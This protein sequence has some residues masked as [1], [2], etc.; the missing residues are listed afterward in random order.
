MIRFPQWKEQEWEMG[1]FYK[2]YF[3]HPLE[4][5]YSVE[6]KN[7]L[8]DLMNKSQ[9]TNMKSLRCEKYARKSKENLTIKD[10]VDILANNSKLLINLKGLFLGEYCEHI[11]I[12]YKK[13]KL[14]I[15]SIYPIFKAYPSLEV[16][17][18]C[19]RMVEEDIFKSNSQLLEIRSSNGNSIIPNKHLTHHNL[20][21]LIVEAA[22]ISEKNLAKICN[23]DLP[24]LE[25]FE[26]C[27]GR[28]YQYNINIEALA[29]ILSG[30]SF[31]NLI[32]LAIRGT[33]NTNEIA[34]GIAKS[35]ILKKLRVLELTDGNLANI[36]ANAL[37]QFPAI[38]HLHTL[39]I[40]GN[41]LNAQMLE[42]LSQLKCR[43]RS[44]INYR[45]YSV[46]E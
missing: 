28:D 7:Q 35:P 40:S 45:Y 22:E 29:P 16:L 14:D 30:K 27:L 23:L 32:F 33:K 39:D 37:I 43:V 36:G 17:H 19:G 25:Y 18:L 34:D 11:N 24:S 15:S 13:S 1:G 42:K 5:L 31:P 4:R 12:K 3:G 38:N 44:H 8:L 26:L 41:S 20:K 46:W 21:S 9:A 2:D 6:N 10:F